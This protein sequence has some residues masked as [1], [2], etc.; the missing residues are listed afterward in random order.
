MLELELNEGEQQILIQLL[1]EVISDLRVEI[2]ATE[3][4]DF[5]MGL[6]AKKEIVKKLQAAIVGD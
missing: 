4:Y 3:T 5:R 2:S 6:K 1:E